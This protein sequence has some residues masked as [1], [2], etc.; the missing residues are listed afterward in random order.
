MSMW[1]K[2]KGLA[3]LADLVGDKFEV[4]G[5]M[6]LFPAWW[7]RPAGRLTSIVTSYQQHG[8]SQDAIRFIFTGEGHLYCKVTASP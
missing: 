3:D 1:R 6:V 8:F 2:L 5:M 4:R 7:T